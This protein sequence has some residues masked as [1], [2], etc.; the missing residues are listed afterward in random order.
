MEDRLRP[1]KKLI[2]SFF[3]LL[4]RSYVIGV[5]LMNL[6]FPSLFIAATDATKNADWL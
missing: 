1:F 4:T 2:S 6:S 3:F 5:L